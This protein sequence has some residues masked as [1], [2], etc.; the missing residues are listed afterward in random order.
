MKEMGRVWRKNVEN[1]GRN[2]CEE[3]RQNNTRMSEKIN[4]ESNR[5]RN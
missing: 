5:K 2:V 4:P 1:E 3:E